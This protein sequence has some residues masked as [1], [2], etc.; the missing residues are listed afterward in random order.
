MRRSLN[1]CNLKVSMYIRHINSVLV[2]RINIHREIRDNYTR[3]HYGMLYPSK[4]INYDLIEAVE[5]T[6]RRKLSSFSSSLF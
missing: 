6:K 5:R 1:T 3:T 2:P 4:I